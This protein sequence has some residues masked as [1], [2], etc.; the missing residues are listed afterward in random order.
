TLQLIEQALAG[1]KL[2]PGAWTTAHYA[3]SL[4]K[5]RSPAARGRLAQI[6]NEAQRSGVVQAAIERAGFKGVH[7]APPSSR[8]VATSLRWA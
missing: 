1:S 4:P 5:G 7:V 3:V 8:F 6:V 2:V